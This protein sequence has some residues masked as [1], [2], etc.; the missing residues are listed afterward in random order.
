[1]GLNENRKSLG[2][3]AAIGALAMP[4]NTAISRCTSSRTPM[5]NGETIRLHGAI[6]MVAAVV[7]VVPRK[8]GPIPAAG[9]V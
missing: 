9:S 6:R 3:S 7:A 5:L 4:P 1:M 2:A 8:R